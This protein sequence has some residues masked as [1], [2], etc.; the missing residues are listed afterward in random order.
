[1]S[2]PFGHTAV[3][4]GRAAGAAGELD[5]FPTPPWA[6]RAGG[7]LALRLDPDAAG[8]WEPACGEGHMAV[9]LCETF[10]WVRASDV[11]PYG[12]GSVLDFLS[13]DAGGLEPV[14]WIITNPPFVQAEAFVRQAWRLARRGVAMLV[15]LQFHEGAARFRLFGELR[16]AASFAFAERVPMVKGRWDPVASS[17][18]AYAWFLWLK[19]KALAAS[20]WRAAIE[21]AWGMAPELNSHLNGLIPPGTRAR[22]SRHEDLERFGEAGTAPLFGE[23][24]G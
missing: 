18:T 22:L 24:G 8:C 17:A 6:A 10:A 19:P 9:P 13:E 21:A 15:R 14:D 16:V 11:H 5:Y 4:A 20:P 7:E 12:H 23:S 1:M 3:M 2:L